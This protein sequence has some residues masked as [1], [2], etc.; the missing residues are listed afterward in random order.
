MNFDWNGCSA[1]AATAP[2]YLISSYSKPLPKGLLAIVGPSVEFTGSD[3]DIIREFLGD[4]GTVLLADDFG[5]GN[6]LL[7]ALN[8]SAAFA[9]EPIADLLDYSKNPDFP[10]IVAFTPTPI[11]VNVTSI[12]MNKPS[13]IDLKN[14]TQAAVLASSS[15]FSFIDIRGDGIP[16]ANATIRAYPVMAT[17]NIS[18]GRLIL[19][20]DSGMFTNEMINLFDNMRMFRNMLHTAGETL[21]FDVTHLRKA[22]LTQPRLQFRQIADSAGTMVLAPERRMYMQILVFAMVFLGF[23]FAILR[24]RRQRRLQRQSNFKLNPE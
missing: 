14:S 12:V 19:I 18:R 16:T 2:T 9:G 24:D 5:T 10:L 17:L 1:L 6:S 13:Y 8:V 23:C 21:L 22:P 11:T 15:P 7:H 4:G 3:A 20:A